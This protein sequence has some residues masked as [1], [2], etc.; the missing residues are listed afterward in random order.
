MAHRHDAKLDKFFFNTAW[1][2]VSEAVGRL[3]GH[4]MRHE[5]DQLKS[6]TLER[7]TNEVINELKQS[8]ESHKAKMKST[9][10][11]MKTSYRIVV[12]EK[13]KVKQKLKSVQEQIAAE[14][15][16]V[17]PKHIREQMKEQIK[18]WQKKDDM[19]VATRAS[20]Y[21]IKCLE[22]HNCVTLTAP[23]GVGK[24]FIARHTALILQRKGYK[25]IP[26]YF[27]IDIRNYY[28]PGKHTVF[29]VDDVCGNFTANQQQI[30][31]WRQLLPLLNTIIADKCCKIIVSCRLQVYKDDKFNIL[32]PFKSCECNLISDELRL[33]SEEKIQIANMYMGTRCEGLNEV[34]KQCEFFP[35]LCYLYHDKGDVDATEFFKNPFDVYKNELDNLCRHGEEGNYKVCS[36]ALCVLLNNQ[37]I[38]KWFRGKVTSEQRKIIEDTCEA[39]KLNKNTPK[40]VLKEAL[41][42]LDGT[43]IH[44]QNGIYR[45]LHD[46]LFD[47][48][49]HYFG[50][51]M[52]ECLIDHGDSDLVRERF[53]WQKSP[54]DKDNVDFIIEI[55]DEYIESYL[56]RLI[57]DWSFGRVTCVFD[58][59][60]LAVSS[61]RQQL[62]R[63]LL[64]LDKS[65]QVALAS[66]KD[67]AIQK[68]IYGSGNTPLILSCYL[69]FTDMVQWLLHNDV[70]VDQCRDDGVTGMYMAC[71]EGET[72]IV[73][74]LLDNNP[75]LDLCDNEGVTALYWACY[76]GH[77]AIVKMIIEKNHKVNICNNNGRSPLYRA[78]LNGHT[79]IVRLLLETDAYVDL[80]DNFDCSPLY[81]AS[82]SGHTD[83]VRL[84]LERDANVNL[85]DKSGNS[86]LIQACMNEH[87]EIVRL[88]L[89]KNPNVDLCNND[90]STPLI[91]SC[92][93][94]NISIVQLLID[95]KP[96]INAQTY[97]GGNALYFSALNG[98][99]RITQLLLE[100]NAD[101]NI[102]IHSKQCIAYTLTNHP[103]ITLE[104][105]KQAFLYSFDKSTSS[106]LKDYVRKKSVDY[107][108]DVVAGSTPLHIACFMGRTDIVRCLLD[109][110]AN[111][112]L[113]KEDGTTPLF[114]AC[115]VGHHDIVRILLDKGANLEMCRLDRKSPLNIATDNGHHGVVE[116]V[117]NYQS[118]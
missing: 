68:G 41:D 63:Y 9:V 1:E 34:A 20:D 25:I 88:L 3:G 14:Q 84:L 18:D 7:K 107:A 5:C 33:I 102:C 110:S 72:T 83:I 97:D 77:T 87:I 74:I 22:N 40:A 89:G 17:I 11:R 117:A 76:E 91:R 79:D 96:N 47:F 109:H 98:N 13:A 10:K 21:V 38:V 78:C 75:N 86:P 71:Q 106:N 4:S 60:N 70:D 39:C 32:P 105:E 2:V 113:A 30:E 81:M 36:L 48:L 66:T 104:Q 69:G 111:I 44:T 61:F 115:E 93:K 12:H 112:N 58:N 55:P 85:F 62:V 37:N 56:E 24:S 31:S 43:F 101:C 114:Y 42:T 29:I 103:R 28:Q 23:A 67:T 27:P 65:Q 118:A 45:T 100:N 52:I 90:G 50:H 116:M 64:Q 6:K 99:E 19:F 108:F 51:K 54:D 73:N 95:H 15:D 80:C 49:A 16:E 92:I 59:T 46:K 57:K 8:I 26:V 53:L 82:Q 35:L 94:N